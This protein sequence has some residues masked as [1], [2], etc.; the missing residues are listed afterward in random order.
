MSAS[1]ELIAYLVLGLLERYDSA[2][3]A[4]ARFE[5]WKADGKTVN[6]ILDL[7]EAERI[8]ASKAAHAAVDKM[9]PEV[10]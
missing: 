6:E 10:G 5:Q 2:R 1:P 3:A 9:P 8:A 4:F 7:L